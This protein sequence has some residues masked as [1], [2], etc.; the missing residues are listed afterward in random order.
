MDSV[1]IENFSG[2]FFL[3]SNSSAS[4]SRDV[5]LFFFSFRLRCYCLLCLL[6]E[7]L[8]IQC[9]REEKP[10]I[11]N[12]NSFD[13]VP[14]LRLLL[15]CTS[16]HNEKDQ[17]VD[18]SLC[19]QYGWAWALGNELQESKNR[20]CVVREKKPLQLHIVELKGK[21]SVYRFLHVIPN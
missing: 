7:V 16:H 11:T 15:R 10:I 21:T 3:I 12:I 2:V 9:T 14:F 17:S 18:R 19:S 13:W 5:A 6:A 20:W 4:S 8:F 1:A